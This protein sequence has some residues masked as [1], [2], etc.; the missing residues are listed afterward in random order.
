MVSLFPMA[1]TRYWCEEI[2]SE[3]SVALRRLSRRWAER[4]SGLGV[5]VTVLGSGRLVSV[6]LLILRW[7]K[8]WHVFCLIEYMGSIKMGYPQVERTSGRS[9]LKCSEMFVDG[10][11]PLG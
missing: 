11:K 1:G 5:D 10:T 9:F 4:P 2:I 6:D 8:Y 7:M 3:H